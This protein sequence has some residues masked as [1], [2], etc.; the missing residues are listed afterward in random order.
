MIPVF[1]G[2]TLENIEKKVILSTFELCNHNQ[3]QT[4]EV[5]GITDR[6]IRNKFKK[7]MEEKD[8]KNN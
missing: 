6:T 2:D 5:L 7:Y 8:T 4:A 1:I 3:K